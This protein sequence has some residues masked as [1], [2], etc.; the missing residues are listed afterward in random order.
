[1]RGQ[2]KKLSVV[3]VIV[4]VGSGYIISLCIQ[5]MLFPLFDVHM[6]IADNALMTL[7]FTV[8]SLLRGYIVR[9]M[10]NKIK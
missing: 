4:N 2:S 5:I 8:I 9:R 7:A 1:M 3:E 10:F 6:S